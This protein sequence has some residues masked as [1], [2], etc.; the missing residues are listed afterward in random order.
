MPR[1]HS[2][3]NL[4]LCIA[5]LT[6]GVGAC[7]TPADPVAASP[8]TSTV[9]VHRDD[10]LAGEV[11]E[12]VRS[13]GRLRVATSS[14][15]PPMT[16][17]G[18]DNTTLIGFDV[19]MAA[20]LATKLGLDAD[21]RT[22]GFDTLIPSLRSGRFDLAMSSIGVTLE[23]QKQVDFASYYNGGQGFLATTTTDFPVT[24]I[25]QL[26]GRRAPQHPGRWV[27][28]GV[29]VVMSVLLAQ[30]V[31]TNPRYEWDVAAAYLFSD[32]I[33]SG[34]L[35]TIELT[36]VSMVIGSLLGTALAV[37][38]LSS[39]AL[40]AGAVGAYVWVFRATPLLVQLLF[41]YNL[42]ALYPRVS[43]GIPFGPELAGTSANTL[44]SP[45]TA[46][47]LA[48][49][50][51]QAAYTAEIVR[52]GIRS[53]PEGQRDASAAL[54]MSHLLTL[55]RIVLPQAM[56]AIIPSMGNEVVSMMKTTSLVSVL[57]IPELLNSAETV[58][59]RTYQTIPLL[60]VAT[61]WYLVLTGVL[62]ALQRVV[63]RRFGRGVDPTTERPSRLRRRARTEPTTAPT[64][65]C[66]T[67]LRS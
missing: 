27:A 51:H 25:E 57:A 65:V 35:R 2:R 4:L 43:I 46:A 8:P 3:A 62:T 36:V 58:Y 14:N 6:L 19:D 1:S 44:I 53:V 20:A 26:C 11:P 47:L 42:A 39:N 5:A 18:T 66:A 33:L 37:L 13:V 16:Y 38:R 59:A 64:P 9:A 17:V 7:A 40:L 15:L 24:T 48:L 49:C 54:G 60:I 22:T 50:L 63:E 56:R 45:W 61:I 31:V 32:V 10:E 23:R 67:E 52:A 30:S 21:V 28:L 29:L 55:R 12:S 41:W 34:L